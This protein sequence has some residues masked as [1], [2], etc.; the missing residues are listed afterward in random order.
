MAVSKRKILKYTLLP[1]I[2]PRTTKLFGTGFYHIAF[3]IAIIFH[4]VRLLPRNHPYLQAANMG[5]FGTRHVIAEAARNLKMD[6]RNIDQTFIFCTILVGL[7]LLSFQ[8]VLIVFSLL[9]QPVL[10]GG[11]TFAEWFTIPS[12]RYAWDEE[13][14]IALMVLDRVFGVGSTADPTLNI[15]NT[16]VARGIDC[17][18]HF[19]AVGTPA[20][21][22]ATFPYPI[23]IAL[24][25]LFRMYSVGISII[26]MM[27][28]LYFIVTIVGET[29]VSGTPFGQRFNRT[30]APV[31][32]IVFFAL[33]APLNAGTPGRDGLNGAQLITLYTAKFGSNFATNAW[34]SFNITTARAYYRPDELVAIPN[35]PNVSYLA[36]FWTVVNACI[37]AEKIVNGRDIRAY[38][39]K[40]AVPASLPP[41]GGAIGGPIA[42]P[43]DTT[44]RDLST[45][46]SA[47]NAMAFTG[48]GDATIVIGVHDPA[49]YEEE[50]GAVKPY[51][52]EITVPVATPNEPGAV[53]A[54]WMY[55]RI[56]YAYQNL[57]HPGLPAFN[58]D[59]IN[60]SECYMYRNLTLLSVDCNPADP[61]ADFNELISTH[62]NNINVY[63]GGDAAATPAV[64][65]A[66]RGVIDQATLSDFAVTDEIMQRGWAG[67]AMWYNRIAQ[68]NGSLVSALNATPQINRWPLI[69]E[70]I[71]DAQQAHSPTVMG[72]DLFNI[73]LPANDENPVDQLVRLEGPQ[74]TEM[75]RSYY[76]LF[77][78]WEDNNISSNPDTASTQNV[79]L[80]TINSVFG[81]DGLFDMRKPTTG[82]FAH[83]DGNLGVHPLAL[84]SSLGRSLIEAAI[85]NLGVAAGGTL[86]VGLMNIMGAGNTAGAVAI[87][88]AS[89]FAG[90]VA[91]T[92]ILI[93]FMLY[94][95]LPFMPFIYFFFALGGWVKSIFEAMVAMPIWALAHIRIDG[96][97]MP[98]PGASNGYFLLLEIFIRPILILVGLIASIVIFGAMVQILNQIFDLMV[99]NISGATRENPDATQIAFYRGPIDELFYSI[100]YAAIVYMMGLSC[101]KLIDQVPSNILRWMGVSVSTFQDQAGDQ[102]SQVTSSIYQ[103][104]NMT[105]GQLSGFTEN[106]AGRVAAM[107]R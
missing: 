54:F 75:A 74:S 73:L 64:V 35:V 31:R 48:G 52:G 61:Y 6:R 44:V 7:L 21:V 100:M 16:C 5:R 39:V 104:G 77:K 43:Y 79:I 65:G 66:I 12:P 97:G 40:G 68:I 71:K 19:G 24:H 22:T 47:P 93:G 18:N 57:A 23:H 25:N 50:K 56:N 102:V 78:I 42:A 11:G 91:T 38:L 106:N 37:E 34:G 9:T 92:I 51:C 49:R 76:Q 17:L 81:A 103:K 46:M 63:V 95:V 29:A 62:I 72:A 70:T 89:S 101:F 98:G 83:P 28:I 53:G 82:G 94:Y 27:I 33:I 14:D 107:I 4:S 80:D 60:M 15:F 41:V 58:A 36:Q 55:W 59:I 99:N 85:R 8:I 45:F 88:T 90:T 10:A 67:A 3:L 96:D 87:Q 105:I 32:L 86:G 1:E 30:W 2:L 69:M 84:L 20:P 26:S 13:R